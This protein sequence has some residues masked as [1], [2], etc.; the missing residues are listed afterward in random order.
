MNFPQEW[1]GVSFKQFASDAAF[2][3]RDGTPEKSMP[4]FQQAFAEG[5]QGFAV[6]FVDGWWYGSGKHCIGCDG[7]FNFNKQAQTIPS[8]EAFYRQYRGKKA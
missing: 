8:K 7:R 5:L 4:V 2:A 3:L 1:A 6:R